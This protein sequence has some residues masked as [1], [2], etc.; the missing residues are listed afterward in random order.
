MQLECHLT[1]TAHKLCVLQAEY[2]I[3]FSTQLHIAF[4]IC[5]VCFKVPTNTSEITPSY[6]WFKV[7]GLAVL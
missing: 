7:L 4:V 6:F 1:Q 5:L 2:K 3:M